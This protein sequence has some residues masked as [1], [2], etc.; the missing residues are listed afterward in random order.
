MRKKI[1]AG[2]V[3]GLVY[4]SPVAAVAAELSEKLGTCSQLEDSLA[5][6]NCYDDLANAVASES[7]AVAPEKAFAAFREI[8]RADLKELVPEERKWG[9]TEFFL[10]D[11]KLFQSS[12]YPARRT[13]Y[14]VGLKGEYPFQKNIQINAP[15][16]VNYFDKFEFWFLLLD[17]RKVDLDKTRMGFT[18]SAE[19]VMQRGSTVQYS[20]FVASNFSGGRSDYSRLDVW[21]QTAARQEQV[22]KLFLRGV[23]P[24]SWPS[25]VD[26]EAFI[27]KYI[28]G[29][30]ALPFVEHKTSNRFR[31]ESNRSASWSFWTNWPEDK[32]EIYERF[33]EVTRACQSN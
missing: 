23:R 28:H 33:I 22:V 25:L 4:F 26:D 30:L 29:E 12:V 20:K 13:Y 21:V 6:L 11:C 14:V 8:A 9:A 5:R 27:D 24:A 10:Q 32:S 3:A 7:S 19:I 1:L 17:L 18:G 16:N 31:K 2:A 15:A